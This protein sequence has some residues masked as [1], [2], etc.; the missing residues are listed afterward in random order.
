VADVL[1]LVGL[2]PLM[3]RTSG[4][5]DVVVGLIDGP[6]ALD[7]PDLE[8]ERLRPLAPAA[9]PPTERATTATRHG[10]F[11]AGIL[12][13]RRGSAAPALCPGCSVVSRPVFADG[14]TP[15]GEVRSTPAELAR[16]IDDCLDAGARVLNVS[17]ALTSPV[18]AGAAALTN[19]LDR[20]A[21][22]GALVVVAAGN[23]GGI[24]GSLLTGHPWV[25]PVT[26][27]SNEGRPS[28][29]STLGLGIGRRGLSAPGD[30]ITSL[31]TAGG[32]TTLSGTSAAVPFVTGAIALLWSAAPRATVDAIRHAILSA[33]TGRRSAVVP[34]LLNA[35][36]AYLAL[37][38]GTA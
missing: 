9:A 25:V 36:A 8:R 6:V 29:Y 18:A 34:P 37:T 17:A 30:R 2:H 20:A 11:V 4:R 13:G 32:T 21:R 24:G 19:A 23:D 33:G 22:R 3:Q 31:D 1:T 35:W 28:P 26:A 7:H 16:A 5:P 10:T 27:C 15:D 14:G 38:G 12:I